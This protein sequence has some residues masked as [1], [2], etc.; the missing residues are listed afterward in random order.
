M[1]FKATAD[2]IFGSVM[3]QL[4]KRLQCRHSPIIG[5]ITLYATCFRKL[6]KKQ[7]PVL[8]KY[9]VFVISGIL[10]TEKQNHNDYQA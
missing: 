10:V 8:N 7:K 3:N 9:I 1:T 6:L 5:E 4:C 2:T